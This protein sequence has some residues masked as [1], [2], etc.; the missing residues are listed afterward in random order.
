LQYRSE[1]DEIFG[2]SAADGR[3]IQNNDESLVNP[4]LM[5]INNRPETSSASQILEEEDKIDLE[6]IKDKD[7]NLREPTT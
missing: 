7:I 4:S 1:L 2:G 6:L 3:Y 5:G